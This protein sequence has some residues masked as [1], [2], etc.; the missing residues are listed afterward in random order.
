MHLR[1]K[2][3]C[4]TKRRGE[5]GQH[6]QRCC[7]VLSSA[8]GFWVS[9]ICGGMRL[10]SSLPL[11]AP[12]VVVLV[13]VNVNVVIVSTEGELHSAVEKGRVAAAAASWKMFAQGIVKRIMELS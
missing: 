3:R 5:A 9:P 2:I 13:T 8:F 11:S 12:H 7:C 1:D 4:A 6:H 10:V